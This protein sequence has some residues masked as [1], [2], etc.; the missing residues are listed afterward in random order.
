M[1]ELLP[2]IKEICRIGQGEL[3]CRY[4]TMAPTGW[5]C[6]K[7]TAL[8]LLLDNRVKYNDMV[9]QGDNCEGKTDEFL[10]NES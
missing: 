4:L 5:S 8:Q 7:G 9:A 2:H 3:C 6:M 1:K 10:N